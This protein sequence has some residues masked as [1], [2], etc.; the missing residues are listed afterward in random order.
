MKHQLGFYIPPLRLRLINQQCLDMLGLF[1]SN[2][3]H[4][5]YDEAKKCSMFREFP[6][7][8]TGMM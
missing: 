6:S 7:G 5:A 3:S 1:D 2:V 8:H 4:E